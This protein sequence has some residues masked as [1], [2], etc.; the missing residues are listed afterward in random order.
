MSAVKKTKQNLPL[1]LLK[2]IVVPPKIRISLYVGRQYSLNALKRAMNS[3]RKIF[4]V[5]QKDPKVEEFM[6][7]NIYQVGVKAEVLQ[8]MILPDG[9][10]KI[11][12][13]TDHCA[14]IQSVIKD[15]DVYT[16]NY[17]KCPVKTTSSQKR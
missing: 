17:K 7:D 16:V 5:S 8:A 15:D 14:T 12:V 10:A 1:I 11:F 4:L 13:Q 9:S 2:D 6:P 3:H